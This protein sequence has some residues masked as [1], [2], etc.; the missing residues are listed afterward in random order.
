MTTIKTII[1]H[2]WHLTFDYHLLGYHHRDNLYFDIAPPFGLRSSA[3]MCQTTTSA[4]TYMYKKLGY[5]CTNY[6][7]DF[8][9]AE[10]P[11]QSV[12]AFLALEDLLRNLGLIT[13]PEKDSPPATSM[14]F[15]GVLVDTT[16][17]TI[18]VTSDRLSE[19]HSR[20]ESL[21]SVTHV[22]RHDLQ[23]LLGVMS[24][25]TSCV[26][27]A[28]LGCIFVYAKSGFSPLVI[29]STSLPGTSL[30]WTT[31]SL[32]TLV[33]GIYL[34]FITRALP[35]W[36]LTC[37]PST[38]YA[39][40]ICFSSRLNANM[41]FSLPL[42]AF[43][44]MSPTIHQHPRVLSSSTAFQRYRIRLTL[45]ELCASCALTGIPSTGSA[46]LSP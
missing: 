21:L 42:Q 27:P 32:I 26:R 40:L 18:S 44:V 15:L 25:V 9:G 11:T 1:W 7:D 29:T 5:S 30:E 12:A 34:Q 3:M 37:P 23:S 19:L 41:V 13:S 16:A 8:G 10:T 39:H 6:I 36:Q 43:P 38:F 33:A 31:P 28:L 35:P 14:V 2:F 45:Q 4:V 24:F 22:S 17:M 20:C 46:K